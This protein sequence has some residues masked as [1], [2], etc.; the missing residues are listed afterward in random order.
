M[1]RIFWIFTIKSRIKKLIAN[2]EKEKAFFYNATLKKPLSADET[3]YLLSR[4]EI[5]EEIIT[6]LKLLL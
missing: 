3:K 1:K 5:K 2:R 6:T 4:I